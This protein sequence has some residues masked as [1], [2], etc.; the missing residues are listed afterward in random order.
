MNIL[1]VIASLGVGGAQSFLLRMLSEFPDGHNIY[2]YEVHPK[3]R[4][5]E[6]LSNLTRKIPIYSSKYEQIEIQFQKYPKVFTKILN[7]LNKYIKLRDITDKFFFNKIIKDKKIQIINSHMYLADSFV[8]NYCKYNIPKISTF[9][10]CYNLLLENY[11]DIKRLK[12]EVK[13]IFSNY[14]GIIYIAEKQK[15]KFSEINSFVHLK[16]KK[17]Y[18]GSSLLLINKLSIVQKYNISENSF[19]FGMAARGDITKGWQEAIDA[20]EILQNEFSNIFL[21]LSGGTDYLINL[22]N[23]YSLNKKIIFTGNINN[24]LDYIANYNVGLLPTYFPAESLPNTVI[25]Y[26]YCGKPVIATDWAEIPKMIE[27]EGKNAGE[28]ISLTK[29]K[30]DVKKLYVAM[31]SYIEDTEKLNSHS[32][33]AKQ[34]FLKFDMQKC[35]NTYIDFFKENLIK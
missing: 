34:A 18:N 14:I 2:L 29:G 11:K 4:E 12:N 23:K 30:A 6:I 15:E 28:I 20:F 5:P 9:H 24:P 35:I 1:F 26:L 7:R 25:E 33:I 32:L 22:K 8:A 19:I 10:G 17:I 16:L 31:K 3:K 27:F 13:F 21:L